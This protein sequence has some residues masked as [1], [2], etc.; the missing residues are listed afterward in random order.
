MTELHIAIHG[1]VGT[2][3]EPPPRST[4]ESHLH[5]MGERL[6][7]GPLELRPHCAAVEFSSTLTAAGPSEDWGAVQPM[8]WRIGEM[9]EKM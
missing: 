7:V 4:G 8:G 1:A 6:G 5:S 2:F 9:R 3:L